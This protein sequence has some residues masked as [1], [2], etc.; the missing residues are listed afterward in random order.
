MNRVVIFSSGAGIP[1]G[2]PAGAVPE[3]ERP[4][5]RLLVAGEDGEVKGHAGL[6][7]REAPPMEG[8][9]IGAVGGFFAND[10]E[11]AR[12]LLAEAEERLRKEGC[13]LAVGPM[14][15]NTWRRYRFADESDGREAFLLEP[16]NPPKYPGWWRM[17]GY[18]ELSCYSSS[19]MPLDGTEA[20]PAALRSRIERS[21]VVLRPLEVGRYD[22]ELRTIHAL[23][24]KAFSN[25]FLYTPLEEEGFL[26][27][28]RK[29]KA[30]VDPEFVI[31]AEKDGDACG[32]V[33]GIADLE[34]LKRGA[35][36]AL[37]VKT[38]AVD[39]SAR[40]AGLGSLLVDELHRAGR[41]KGFTEAI[42]ALQHE[43]NTS[44]KITGRH[45]GRAFRKYVLFSKRL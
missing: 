9:R 42:H 19:V 43:N 15:G 32:F 13:S 12:A 44:L 35:A 37:I 20:V 5:A 18:S 29:V 21:G 27:S 45:Q 34:A 7:W 28:Y 36:P 2:F 14:N 6:W 26:G 3:T 4:D 41:R 17:A 40:C 22:D 39:P 33:F 23:S 10:E 25:N 1:E 8:E 38:L 31:I 30:F 11:S 16:V 24:L